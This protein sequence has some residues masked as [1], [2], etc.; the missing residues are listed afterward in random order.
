MKIIG[1]YV[2]EGTL[3]SPTVFRQIVLEK[4]PFI[5]L[6]GEIKV[7]TFR[8]RYDIIEVVPIKNVEK[9]IKKQFTNYIL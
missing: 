6:L 3:V 5:R 7:P 8:D 4:V 2:F 1:F 9:I